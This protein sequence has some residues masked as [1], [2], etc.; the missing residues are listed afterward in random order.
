[1]TWTALNDPSLD[2]RAVR[3]IEHNIV[4]FAAFPRDWSV[5]QVLSTLADRFREHGHQHFP[6]ETIELASTRLAP[7]TLL[8]VAPPTAP[9]R[10][11][12]RRAA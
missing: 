4:F 2:E 12:A 8:A 7:V 1:M 3:C 11:P 6:F 5:S 9:A 10:H